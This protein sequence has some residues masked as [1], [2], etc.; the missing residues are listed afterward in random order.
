MSYWRQFVL[1]CGVEP[2]NAK[3][4]LCCKMMN[5]CDQI[6]VDKKENSFF[7]LSVYWW[8]RLF[9]YTCVSC[10]FAVDKRT[11]RSHHLF[12]YINFASWQNSFRLIPIFLYN[13]FLLYPKLIFFSNAQFIHFNDALLS[14]ENIYW[15]LLH[16][17]A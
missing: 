9:G 4:N 13:Y 6:E 7:L 3:F 2:R 11:F 17:M 5:A 1:F 16:L 10:R 15:Y 12:R 14:V 8:T